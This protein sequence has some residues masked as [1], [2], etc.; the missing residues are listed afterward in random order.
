VK[1][2]RQMD[3]NKRQKEDLI[4]NYIIKDFINEWTFLN[5]ALK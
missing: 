2:A 1:G 4:D 5:K 3:T